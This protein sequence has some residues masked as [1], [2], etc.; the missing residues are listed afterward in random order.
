M[1]LSKRNHTAGEIA[2]AMYARTDVAAFQNG[3][4]T[5]RNTIVRK[6][7]GTQNRPGTKY[8]C[9][10]KTAAN[11]VRLIPWEFN[12]DQTY[13]LEFGDY[14]IRFIRNGAQITVSGVSAWDSGTTY[15]IGNLVSK[16]GVNYYAIATGSNKDPATQTAYWYALTGSIYEIPTPYALADIQ[17]LNF[18]QSGDVMTLT[19]PSYAVREL[20]R[21]G[22]TSW[23][24]SL[25]TFAPSISAP[26]GLA[27]SASGTS[28]YYVVTAVKKDT[29]EESLPTDPVGA[30]N[31]TSTLSWAVVAD[32]QEYNVYK[33]KKG[34]YGFIGVADSTQFID[35][36]IS[37]DE[38]DTPPAKRNPFAVTPMKTVAVG[39]G[40]TG[41]AKGDILTITQT[42]AS[43]GKV[44]VE[45]VNAGAVT[46][47]SIY[48]P[49]QNYSVANGLATTGGTGSN[50]TINIT[51]VTTDNFPST[52]NYYQQ[53]QL[54]GNTNEDTEKIW[55]SKSANYKNMTQ[56]SPLQDDDAVTF[57]VRGR[58]VNSVKHLIDLGKLIV[59]TYG[60]EWVV[61]GDQAGIL[62]AG[63]INQVQ[64]SY[65]GCSFLRPI[66]I[67]D[68]ALYVQSRQNIVRDLKYQMSPD[69]SDGYTGTDLTIMSEHLFEQFTLEDWAF[70]QTPNPIAW[71]VRDDGVLLGLTYLRDHRIFAWHRHDFQ[72]AE[73]ENVAAV[74]EGSEDVLY[75][76]IKRT[77]DGSV[78]R[79][80]EKFASR[81]IDTILDAIFMD[82][83]LSF[84]GRHT[85][86]TT[87]TLSG[88][89]NWT[90]DESL[91]LTASAGF[92]VAGDVGNE[93]HL[94]GADGTI[95][96]CRIMAYTSNT[97]VTVQS[98]KTVPASMRAAAITTWGKAVDELTGLSHLEGEDLAII[99]DGFVVASPNNEAYTVKTVSS[100]SVTLD[101]PYVVIHAGLPFISDVETLD[102]DTASGE[103]LAGE[104]KLVS[105]V[106]LYVE[107]SR[108]IFAGPQPPSDDDTDPLEGLYE[109]KGR[110]AESYDDPT[111]LK[112]QVIEVKVKSLWN[113]NGRVFV[114]QVDPLP[115]NILGIFPDLMLPP[116]RS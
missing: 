54:F 39:A 76:S 74:S 100:G 108:G 29:Y 40:G 11:R 1:L 102:I 113:T 38:A 58:Q 88:G 7:G 6:H 80:I 94:T 17:T 18:S 73:V 60:A 109:F 53:R 37:A 28:H 20:A 106:R 96:R 8:I 91:T 116:T 5:C 21:T 104:S 71:I 47:V 48:D 44:K 46:S 43:S 82:S 101:K 25:V 66:I 16:S 65:N 67:N 77:I 64:Q 92:F 30:S 4:R 45:A 9:S 59:F 86:S 33:K 55:G 99:G 89:T 62:R 41:Y 50:C 23:T 90:Y 27:S 110:N 51:A 3:L 85:G 78:V 2:P 93:I 114:R 79:Y 61:H 95:L 87:M 84:D 42:G 19:H 57:P 34:V 35:A 112:T 107:A 24:L 13:V 98:H 81:R 49:G 68:T 75:L 97:V 15:A 22:H 115:L 105:A 32:A 52:S 10:T 83:S 26:T 56:S 31:E 14:Y 72:D 103:A 69:G 12:S 111:E 70:T 36:T 63:E